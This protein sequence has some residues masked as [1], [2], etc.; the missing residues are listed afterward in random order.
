MGRRI[1]DPG[2]PLPE[3]QLISR[4]RRAALGSVTRNPHGAIIRGIGEDCSVLRFSAGHELLVTTDFSLEDIHFRRD[5]D[6]PEAIG[7]RCLARGLSDI[8]AMGGNPVAAFLSLAVPRD[9]QQA[10]VDAFIRGLLKL[11]KRFQVGLAG[12]DTATS[13][14]GV[15]ADIVVVGSV[16]KG[17]A[18]LRSGARTGDRLFV[19]GSLGSAAQ[20][21][22]ELSGRKRQRAA[23]RVPLLP[24]PRIEVGKFLR[25]RG[26]ASAMIDVSDGLSTDLSHICRESGVGAE[27]FADRLPR[28]FAGKPHRFVDLKYA[29]HGGDDYELL[30]TATAAAR[31]PGTVG[32]VPISEIG[33][34]TR[35]NRI[36]LVAS[37]GARE[38]L[39]VQ[40]WE[41]FARRA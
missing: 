17:T 15:L 35:S 29:L 25:Q 12:G 33:V 23:S 9:V 2:L 22:S 39:K 13:P 38:T 41:H 3:K 7:H 4:L 28:G 31:V 11:A 10:W 5:W 36:V 20:R 26:L 40:G 32:N 21:V 37:N 19:T 27:I 24:M 18:V 16:P 1:I 6:S 34:I 8:A 14:E 30:F